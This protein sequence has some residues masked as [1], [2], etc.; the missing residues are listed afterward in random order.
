V[1]LPWENQTVMEIILEI[2]Q[3]RG[4]YVLTKPIHHSQKL[5][6]QTETHLRI[7]LQLI[8]NR[9]FYAQILWYGEDITVISPT[10]IREN[11]KQQLE[12]VMTN[13]EI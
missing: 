2:K 11:M 6:I 3:P 7:S 9:E 12:K 13:Y 5:I 8:P 10:E 1:G 4:F